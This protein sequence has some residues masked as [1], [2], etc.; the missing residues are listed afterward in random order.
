M[1]GFRESFGGWGVPVARAQ[2]TPDEMLADSQERSS[3]EACVDA[4]LVTSEV[5]P[6]E[7]DGCE[8]YDAFHTKI[9]T[10]CLIRLP[11]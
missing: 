5:M 10:A 9:F 1:Q 4:V 3:A 11:V 8:D 7:R 6:Y 2:A